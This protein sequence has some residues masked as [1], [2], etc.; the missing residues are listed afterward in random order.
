L[1]A[2]APLAQ[3]AAGITATAAQE[4]VPGYEILGEL[5]R[6]GM[7]V[8]YRARQVKA[9]RLVA[10]KMILAG[11]HAGSGELARFQTEAQAIAALQHPHIVQ[12]FEVGEHDGLPFFSLEFCPGGS[13]EKKLSGTPLAPAEAASLVEK[14]ARAM[15]AA[16]SK[17]VIHRDLKPANVLLAEDGTPKITDFGLAKKLD[18]ES[19][20]TRSGAIVGTPSYMAPEQAGGKKAVGP[21]ADVYAL[22]AILYECLT[23]RPPFRAATALDTVLQV[24]SQEPVSPAQLNAKT[25]RDLKT[26]CLK[27][28]QKDAGKRY[29]S[30]LALA[31]DLGR[32]QRGEPITARPVGRLERGWRWCKRNPALA[33]ALTA[34]LLL[35][36]GGAT[37]STILALVASTALGQAEREAENAR[38]NEEKAKAS[39]TAA[40]SARNKLA[41]SNDNLLT[42]VARSLLRPLAAQNLHE[43]S[44]PEIDSLWELASTKEDRLRLRFVQEALRGPVTMRQLKDRAAV[45]MQAAVGLDSGTR[46]QMQHLLGKRLEA[47]GIESD[48]QAVVALTLAHLGVNDQSVAGRTI[49]ILTQAMGQTTHPHEWADLSQGVSAVAVHLDQKEASRSAALLALAIRMTRNPYE[50]KYYAQCLSVVASC[51]EPK[52]SAAVCGQAAGTLAQKMTKTT[53]T[54]VLP[55][56][57]Q[58]LSLLVARMEAKESTTV[59]ARAAGTLSQAI[60]TTTTPDELKFLSEELS[61]LAGRMEPQEATAVCARAA[62]TLSKTISKRSHPQELRW[63]SEGLA[64]LASRM[65]T[66]AAAAVC[67]QAAGTLSHAMRLTT[68]TVELNNL[69]AGLSAVANRMDPNEAAVTLTQITSKTTPVYSLEYLSQGLAGWVTRL[70]QKQTVQAAATLSQMIS[71]TTNAE[72]LRN[73]SQRLAAVSAR[74]DS[75]D[76]AVVCGQVAGTL[77]QAMSKTTTLSALQFLSRPLLEVLVR[78]PLPTTRR[79]PLSVATTVAG[80]AGATPPI[81]VLA[82]AQPALETV[83]PPLPAQTLVDLLKHP[84]C[85]GEARRLVLQQLA[86]HYNR[87]FVDQWEFVEYVHQQKLPLDLITPPQR[88]QLPAA[89]PR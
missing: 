65:E 25:P 1:P 73:L 22:G 75:K 56:I 74:L 59:C 55:S 34:V 16:H 54:R 42:S 5:G 80:L 70:S 32:Y 82:V 44:D 61:V 76:A 41:E 50:L 21:A 40:V 15:A 77:I 46:T 52:E 27:C 8:V 9:N 29:A 28:L 66:K 31:E 71:K 85:V 68:N 6:G 89:G 87:P 67:G 53:S 62:A 35:L 11:G 4:S 7:G 81:D 49:T 18:Q 60:T 19:G 13:L 30:A 63:L 51:L 43:L 48:E 37:V 26:I 14:L 39:E 45:A 72:E 69:S 2:S 36:V 78:E 33:S 88:S 64:A 84:F 3:G 83:P 58:G 20:Q 24:V 10:L 23:G 12:V 79:R 38:R 86:R 17:G 47:K 57:A